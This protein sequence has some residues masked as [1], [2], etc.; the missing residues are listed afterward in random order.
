M[1][2]KRGKGKHRRSNPRASSKAHH[3]H[4]RRRR[5]PSSDFGTRLGRLALG[6]TVAVGTAVGVTFLTGKIAPGN[7]LSLY[8]IPAAT[9][10]AGAAIAKKMPLLGAGM[11]LGAPAP[12]ALPLATKLLLATEP[13]TPATTSAGIARAYRRMGAVHMGA[14]HMGRAYA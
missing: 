7:P 13:A 10:V 2:K 14:V 6:A 1:A 5:N 4:R 11:A 8:G 3:P 9:F 12:F